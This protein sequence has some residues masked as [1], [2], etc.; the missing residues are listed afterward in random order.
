MFTSDE[1]ALC[2]SLKSRRNAAYSLRAKCAVYNKSAL[3]R[4]ST[5]AKSPVAKIQV[6]ANAR[7]LLGDTIPNPYASTG[8]ASIITNPFADRSD[9][10]TTGTPLARPSKIQC[11]PTT[12]NATNASGKT[13]HPGASDGC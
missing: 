10:R 7:P 6:S 9:R 2:F 5:I 13:T 11:A 12:S 3:A 4:I 8:I 1:L